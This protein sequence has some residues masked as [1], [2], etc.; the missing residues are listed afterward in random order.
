MSY[1]PD[2]TTRDIFIR[3]HIP[4]RKGYQGICSICQQ[5]YSRRHKLVQ[6]SGHPQCHCLFGKNCLLKWLG[7]GI[8]ASNTCPDCKAVLYNANGDEVNVEEGES[9]S[10]DGSED[11]LTI[12]ARGRPK[13]NLVRQ[14]YRRRS[15]APS[16]SPSRGPASS[17]NATPS[18]TYN[19]RPRPIL[20][21]PSSSTPSPLLQTHLNHTLR[22]SPSTTT[23]PAFLHTLAYD[24]TITTLVDD[25]WTGTWD[26]VAESRE[27]TPDNATRSRSTTRAQL[28]MLVLDVWP[29]GE[30]VWPAVLERLVV[31]ARKM[32]QKH[33][34]GEDGGFDAEAE[35]RAEREDVR[36][37][38]GY[39]V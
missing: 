1:H 14:L 38:V 26:L 21:P 39:G 3:E 23:L 28:I 33:R 9:G 22:S 4:R 15:H 27:L 25:L 13:G 5:L 34:N 16:P 24:L 32:M 30:E 11:E 36:L 6:I 37:A 7:S 18:H 10:E 17:A 35:L 2:S 31:R 20:P 12:P 8:A 19:L 29:F